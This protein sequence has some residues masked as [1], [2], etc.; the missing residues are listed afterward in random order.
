MPR[1]SILA[2]IVPTER[3]PFTH[4]SAVHTFVAV[5]GVKADSEK[6]MLL[7]LAT[8]R[9][10][11]EQHSK[12]GLLFRDQSEFEQAQRVQVQVSS[13]GSK[14]VLTRVMRGPNVW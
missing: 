2:G 8:C 6:E 3:D 4:L 7:L 5:K 13:N 12:C 14:C 10:L 9:I 1:L 11:S